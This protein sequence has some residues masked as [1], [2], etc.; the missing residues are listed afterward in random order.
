VRRQARLQPAELLSRRRAA[1]TRTAVVP[2]QWLLPPAP[3]TPDDEV[4]TEAATNT[5]ESV[6]ETWFGPPDS[7]AEPVD[8]AVDPADT[9]DWPSDGGDGP[10]GLIDEGNAEEGPARTGPAAVGSAVAQLSLRHVNKTYPGHPPL[11]VLRDVSLDIDAGEFVAVV[12]PS[13]SG[14]TTMLSIMGTLDQ[15]TTGEVWIEGLDAAAVGEVR[16]ARLRSD[17][18]GFVFQQFFLLP[19]LTALD[20]VATGMLYQG[21]DRTERRSRA[22]VALERVG[23]ADRALHRPGELSGGEQQRVA[24]ARA[25]AGDP[26]ILFADEPTGALDQ[27][28]GHMIIDCLRAISQSGTTVI[29]IT[30]DHALAAGFDRTITILDGEVVSDRARGCGDQRVGVRAATGSEAV[31]DP[32]GPSAPDLE[33]SA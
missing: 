33:G 32:H 19:A 2:S 23:L 16:R 27:A 28:S 24:I 8:Q 26:R 11:H 1:A 13:G 20:N 17:A 12:G 25:I 30:H 9:D 7:S 21:I 10:A 14:K 6:L 29:V 15:P 4:A 3:P 31:S 18:I 5:D 22:L